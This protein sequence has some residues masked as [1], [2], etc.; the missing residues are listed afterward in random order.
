V[1][2]RP[3]TR[4]ALLEGV[5]RIRDVLIASTDESER[6]TTLVP[7]A[8]AALEDAGLLG[9]KLPAVLGGAEAD[10]VTQIDVIE[11]VSAI[12]ASAGWCLMVGATTIA[13]PG[14]FLGDGALGTVFA[15]GRIPRAAGLLH[16][17]RPRRRDGRRLS[18]D[19][20][21]GVR[22][23]HSPRRLGVRNRQRRA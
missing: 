6:A 10:P 16:A 19:R 4:Q 7:A 15:H 17:H 22:Q 2:D 11:A 8:V 3:A 5:A 18:R 12:D 13:L 9:L 23:R 20:T 1:T 21:V 14:V